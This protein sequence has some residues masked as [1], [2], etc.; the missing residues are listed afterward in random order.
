MSLAK[1][2]SLFGGDTVR[3]MRYCLEVAIRFPQFRD[4]YEE[5]ARIL[6]EKS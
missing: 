6:K 4:E 2:L 5:Y 3:A 1:I